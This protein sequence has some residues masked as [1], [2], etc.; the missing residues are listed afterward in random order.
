MT[1]LPR[2][3]GLGAF[4][5]IL[6]SLLGLLLDLFLG[7][8]LPLLAAPQASATPGPAAVGDAQTY[9]FWSYWHADDGSWNL[10]TTGPSDH[11]PVDGSVEGWRFTESSG[12]AGDSAS[13][14]PEPSF[15]RICASTPAQQ[16]TKRV[17]V[18]LDYGTAAEVPEGTHPPVPRTACAQV[19]PDADGSEVLEA[20]AEIQYLDDGQVCGIDAYPPAGCSGSGSGDGA[21]S[22]SPGERSAA[23]TAGSGDASGAAS[24]GGKTDA[25]PP[26]GAIVGTALGGLLVIVLGAAAL[27]RARKSS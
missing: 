27:L 20:V 4:T 23:A 19:S 17:A 3:P 22:T 1:T 9:R 25:G 26:V 21:D 12:S 11:Q 2:R 24:D 8:L 10:A 16:G 5:L 15:D 6:G 18:A 14:R 7:L 13:P